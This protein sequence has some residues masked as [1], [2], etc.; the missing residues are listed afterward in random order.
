MHSPQCHF[1]AAPSRL[2]GFLSVTSV[3][4]P[5]VFKMSFHDVH[6]TAPSPLTGGDEKLVL[7]FQRSPVNY[8]TGL[9]IAY[10]L[11]W[12]HG[13]TCQTGFWLGLSPSTPVQV[14]VWGKQFHC[15]DAPITLR[16]LRAGP[17]ALCWWWGGWSNP[18]IHIMLL[19]GLCFE[20]DA[21][22]QQWAVSYTHSL[23]ALRHGTWIRTQVTASVLPDRQLTF[24]D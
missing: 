7:I 9:C 13:F 3:L 15:Q 17:T 6:F 23:W 11:H 16:V 8:S 12:S 14:P 2:N 19:S 1:S 4:Q 10:S 18:C 5:I 20:D 22:G 21:H 24:L